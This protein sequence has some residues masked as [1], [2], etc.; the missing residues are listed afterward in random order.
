[1]RPKGSPKTAGSGRKKGT[2]NRNTIPCQELADSLGINPFEVLLRFAAGQ[3]KALGIKKPL[4]PAIRAKA[5]SEAVKYLH[6]QLRA[7]EHKGDLGIKVTIVDY[8]REKPNA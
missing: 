2:P 4:D 6:H 3:Y 8:T 5:A 1:M 7:H